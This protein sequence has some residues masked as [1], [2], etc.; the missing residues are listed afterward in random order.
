MLASQTNDT[1]IWFR[2]AD[3]VIVDLVTN[4]SKETLV[5]CINWIVWGATFYL[6][7]M[8]ATTTGDPGGCHAVILKEELVS[9]Q[10]AAKAHGLQ[11]QVT[12]EPIRPG[13][14][15]GDAIIAKEG[16]ASF[17]VYYPY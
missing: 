15:D 5:D 6:L 4:E 3:L 11:L 10:A 1:G 7:S 8:D 9:W 17:V 12:D 2:A 14:W 13:V 16:S